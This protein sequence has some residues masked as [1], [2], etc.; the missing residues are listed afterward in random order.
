[1]VFPLP[2][3]P[4]TMMAVGS[5]EST[6]LS[7]TDMRSGAGDAVEGAA[8][9]GEEEAD[10]AGLEEDEEATGLEE[11]EDVEEEALGFDAVDRALIFA[12]VW[13]HV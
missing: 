8:G 2:A 4:M 1:M 10:A 5:G 12:A 7:R 11:E 9:G 3:I 13:M 6:V